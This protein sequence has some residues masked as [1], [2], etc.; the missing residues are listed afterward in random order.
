LVLEEDGLLLRI[1]LLSAVVASGASLTTCRIWQNPL[2]GG[3]DLAVDVGA[4]SC[5]AKFGS[6]QADAEFASANSTFL[7][8]FVHS[9]LVNQDG[10]PRG[11]ATSAADVSDVLTFYGVPAGS[12]FI[13]EWSIVV[14]RI[15][16]DATIEFLGLPVPITSDNSQDTA[17]LPIVN[18]DV[19]ISAS[20]DA[21][22]G[23]TG[24]GRW[25]LVLGINLPATKFSRVID[26]DG[27]AVT[28]FTF[29]TASGRLLSITDGTQV[30]SVP[31]P[32]TWAL[33]IVPFFWLAAKR[34]VR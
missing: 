3:A 13:L 4:T 22:T 32:S 2:D 7:N 15:D 23:W 29:S 8:A 28:G 31:E 1:Y 30:Q 24:F 17:F 9:S 12:T 25:T 34:R 14:N 21:R 26:A 11:L 20:I 27:D 33:L 18:G 19:N 10:T 6:S 5:F 16:A